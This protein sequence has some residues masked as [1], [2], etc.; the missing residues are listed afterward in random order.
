MFVAGEVDNVCRMRVLHPTRP[1]H[2]SRL[3]DGTE[4]SRC[5]YMLHQKNVEATHANKAW[6]DSVTSSCG[7]VDL[8][9]SFRR[10]FIVRSASLSVPRPLLGVSPT[11]TNYI[12]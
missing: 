10:D 9:I 5:I 8:Y 3:D 11:E 1:D 2:I 6:L 7:D 4:S 12:I